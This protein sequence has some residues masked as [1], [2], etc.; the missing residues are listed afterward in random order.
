M[1]VAIWFVAGLLIAGLFLFALVAVIWALVTS[2]VA[3][4]ERTNERR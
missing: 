4:L 2:L 1:T 3:R